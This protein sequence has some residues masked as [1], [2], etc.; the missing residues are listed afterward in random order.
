MSTSTK[1]EHVTPAGD[2]LFADLGFNTEEAADLQALY[3]D[4]KDQG[5]QF[6]GVNV[7]DTAET[8]LAFD[9][10]F[11]ISFP[12][13]MDAQ[14]GGV[15]LAFQGVVSPQAVPTTLV[16]D[17]EGK[18]ASRILGRIDPSILKTLIETVVAE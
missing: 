11:G 9:R 4:F 6:V 16:I 7:R 3:E 5:V 2:N 15:S 8:A 14:S 12:S 1:S 13:I 17:K 10:K 18:V